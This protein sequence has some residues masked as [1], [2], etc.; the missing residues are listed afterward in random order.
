MTIHHGN[1]PL[2]CR[3]A[4]AR[5]Q[6]LFQQAMFDNDMNSIQRPAKRTRRERALAEQLEQA[7]ENVVEA[8]RRRDFD[9][10]SDTWQLYADNVDIEAYKFVSSSPVKYTDRLTRA[11]LVRATEESLC[12]TPDLQFHCEL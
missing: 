11:E 3:L 10:N 9:S 7:H 12:P 8:I 2:A 4:T 1:D 6:V 5:E